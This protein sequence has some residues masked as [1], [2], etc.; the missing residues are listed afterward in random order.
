MTTKVTQQDNNKL[1]K[2]VQQIMEVNN[3]DYQEW[4]FQKH[5]EYLSENNDIITKALK[6]LS[7]S[8]SQDNTYEN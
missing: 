4:L 7:Q 8:N 2:Q 1:K 6:L 5:Q 3:E